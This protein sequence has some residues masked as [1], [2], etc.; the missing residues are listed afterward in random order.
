MCTAPS[1]EGLIVSGES[2]GSERDNTVR[3]HCGLLWFFNARIRAG[4]NVP[5]EPMIRTFVRGVAMLVAGAD[6]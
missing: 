3:S 1:D 2:F 4:A 5:P 6:G